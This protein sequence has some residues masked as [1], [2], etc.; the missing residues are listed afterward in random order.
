MKLLRFLIP[1]A[2]AASLLAASS[3]DN[4]LSQIG[5]A[6]SVGEA[7]INIDSLYFDLHATAVENNDYDSRTGN[8]LLGNLNVPEYGALNCSYVTR[9][10][11]A[12]SLDV[13]DSLR[14]PERVDS[15]ILKLRLVRGDLT[16][17][18]LSPLRINAYRLDRQLPSGISNN[19][20]PEGYYSQSGLLGSKSC[21]MSVIG[22]SDSLFAKKT[23]I[24]IDIPVSA[25]FG[26]EVFNKYADDPSIFEWPQ[27]FAQYFPG[28]FVETSFGKGCVANVQQTA[29]GIYYHKLVDKSTT[30]GDETT[31]TQ[32]HVRDSVYPFITSPEVLSSNN[33]SYKVSD[34]IRDMVADGDMVI[35]TPGGFYTSI[36]F[37]AAE[38]IA[39]YTDDDYNMS[40]VSDLILSIPAEPVENSYGL[41]AAPELLLI[42][43]S[44]MESFF[45]ENR[46]PD[47]KTS[48]VATYSATNGG[49]TF[50]S[51]RNYIL[52]LIEKGS[53]SDEDT[54]FV[55]V[56][57]KLG[58]EEVSS[59][60]SSTSYITQC[61]P[62]TSKPTMTRLHTE[63]ALVVFSFSTQIIK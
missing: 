41:G 51:M 20:D 29:L 48:F 18:S 47:N 14:L 17:D 49:Y 24:D 46:I 34:N 32:I 26:K 13:P 27:S 25:E 44:E 39:R 30:V 12:T 28:L 36:K 61:T 60:Y 43:A 40:L 15:C 52:N 16:G 53:V 10:M 7:T 4:E 5:P 9:L 8:L 45:N 23:Y 6:L 62:Y 63:N 35:T 59:Y 54:D 1:F 42:K 19:F 57:V 22:S 2:G 33:I 11:C 38:V 37:P 3:C 21:V 58:Y 56:P 50:A 55:I 31:V